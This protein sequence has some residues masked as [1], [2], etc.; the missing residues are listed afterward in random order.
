MPTSAPLKIIMNETAQSR[1]HE[2]PLT[3]QAIPFGQPA[4]I[5]EGERWTHRV[6]PIVPNHQ[7][8]LQ[9]RQLKTQLTL[10]CIVDIFDLPGLLG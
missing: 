10:T 3:F 9:S 6:R 2:L 5:R 7:S 4:E 1:A 8:K